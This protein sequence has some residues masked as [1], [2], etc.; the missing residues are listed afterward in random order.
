MLGLIGGLGVPAGIFYYRQLVEACQG[1]EMP[2]KL[3]FAHAHVPR[4]VGHVRS[5]EVREL[6]QYFASLL[7]SLADG[8]AEVGAI[9]AVTPHICIEHLLEISPLPLVSILDAVRSEFQSQQFGRVALL[10]TRYVIESN[11][12]GSLNEFD[13]VRPTADEIDEIDR[14]YLG[15]AVRGGATPEDRSTLIQIAGPLLE[16]ERLDAILIAGTDLS[17]E[18]EADAPDLPMID[19]ARIHVDALVKAASKTRTG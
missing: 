14:A 10:G 6:A 15:L 19:C 17:P 12:Y 3:L 11:L 7:Q 5:G 16:R 9:S 13:I 4:V 18:L 8:G 2:L 1:R